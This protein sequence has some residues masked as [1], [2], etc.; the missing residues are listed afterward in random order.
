MTE[1]KLTEMTREEIENLDN[2]ELVQKFHEEIDSR[3]DGEFENVFQDSALAELNDA[4]EHDKLKESAEALF[5]Y[6]FMLGVESGWKTGIHMNALADLKESAQEF[7]DTVEQL[8]FETNNP[9][10]EYIR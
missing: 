4:V 5:E 8:G 3:E 6:A 9:D 2:E 10:P 7:K 1:K